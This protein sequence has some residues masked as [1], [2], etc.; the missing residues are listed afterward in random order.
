MRRRK[1]LKQRL[2]HWQKWT[3]RQPLHHSEEHQGAQRRRQTAHH[4][5]KAKRTQGDGEHS[6]GAEP[7]GQPAGQRHGDCLGYGIGGNYPRA[8]LG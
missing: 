4:R 1:A 5:E 3:A 7:A 6:D 2:R 8:F